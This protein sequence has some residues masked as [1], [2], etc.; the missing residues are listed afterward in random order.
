MQCVLRYTQTHTHTQK[1][2]IIIIKEIAKR[3]ALHADAK[4]GH[5]KK[6]RL[7]AYFLFKIKVECY[8]ASYRCVAVVSFDSS[9]KGKFLIY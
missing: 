3:F 8:L 5:S 6:K 7:K 2:I 9:S 4:I 1:K